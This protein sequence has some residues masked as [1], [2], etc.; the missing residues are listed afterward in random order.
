MAKLPIEDSEHAII[1]RHLIMIRHAIEHNDQRRASLLVDR[2]F[3]ELEDLR[4][5]VLEPHH[6]I[7]VILSPRV[8]SAMYRRN[9]RTIEDLIKHSE[10]ALLEIP[11]VGLFE[12]K[13]IQAALKK[14]SF[15]L[16]EELF[17]DYDGD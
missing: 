16:R 6:D 5:F 10:A 7:E 8:A 3:Q 14:H 2:V 12:I 15:S 13:H 1:D 11:W 9:I 17:G 4:D